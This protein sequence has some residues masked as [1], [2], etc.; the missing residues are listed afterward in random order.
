MT[1]A[2]LRLRLIAAA[3]WALVAHSASAQ[4]H[5]T[6]ANYAHGQPGTAAYEHFSF[7]TTNGRRTDIYY[8][9]GPD[10]HDSHLRY[11]GPARLGGQPGFKV[12]FPT[13]RTLY[14]APSGTTLL[15]A[16]SP[17][18][19]PKAF[20]WEYEGPVNGVGTVCSVCAADAAA[21]AR[22]VQRHYL[23]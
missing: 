14:L 1:P 2:M 12:Q 15:V 9:Y 5:N 11:L 8:A 23:R 21:A 10:R 22:L 19:T 7:W 4:V 18:A 16:I 20:A 17:T 6:V 13:G 3:G